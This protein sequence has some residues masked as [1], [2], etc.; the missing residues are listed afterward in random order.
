MSPSETL[1]GQGAFDALFAAGRR[2][3]AALVRCLFRFDPGP[4]GCLRVGFSVPRRCGTAVRRNRVR[5]LMREAFRVEKE[6][7]RRALR[8]A[9]RSVSLL[10]VFR[11]SRECAEGPLSMTV[12][13]RDV[14]ELCRAVSEAAARA[15]P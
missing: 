11:G 7:F 8:E 10:F 14:V 12:I 13:H 3:N 1:R 9:G 15:L 6:G 2:A 4:A 5:R